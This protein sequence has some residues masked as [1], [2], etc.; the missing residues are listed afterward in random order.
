M[1][2]LRQTCNIC[3][4]L[5][6]DVFDINHSAAK[7][8]IIFII[9]V[10]KEIDP[11]PPIDHSDYDYEKF[12][13]NFYEEPVDITKLSEDEVTALRSKLDIRVGIIR[14]NHECEGRRE[15]SVPRIAVWH[16]EACRVMT[17]GDPEGQIFLSNPHTNNGFFF[18]LTFVFFLFENK[19]AEVPE[20]AKMQFHMMTSLK[21]N[22]DVT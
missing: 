19:L 11:L 6:V 9:C 22:N 7:V 18:L 15:K 2:F 16:H 5:E 12:S 4:Y 1:G 3:S 14:I 21:H 20:Y 13:K 10:F 17:N 8:I